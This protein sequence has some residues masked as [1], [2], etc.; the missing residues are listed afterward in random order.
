VLAVSVALALAA[1]F[2]P[3]GTAFAGHASGGS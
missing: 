3:T 1:G 2:I